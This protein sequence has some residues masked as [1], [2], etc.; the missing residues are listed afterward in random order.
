MKDLGLGLLWLL[1]LEY[2]IRTPE[3]VWLYLF[4]EGFINEIADTLKCV[5]THLVE[6]KSLF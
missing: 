5:S 4:Q 1:H 2:L 6:A 3:V